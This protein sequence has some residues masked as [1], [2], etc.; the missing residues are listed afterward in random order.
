MCTA[1][2]I[3]VATVNVTKA[4]PL[5]NIQ[6]VLDFYRGLEAGERERVDRALAGTGW[7]DLLAYEP[8]HRL[9]KRGFG[10]FLA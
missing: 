2:T 6:H 5:F 3:N 8:R 1:G 9:E 10:L 4:Y 7:S